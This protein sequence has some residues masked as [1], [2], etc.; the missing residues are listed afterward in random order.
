MRRFWQ[1]DFYPME[2]HTAVIEAHPH[3]TLPSVQRLA[4]C[5]TV[6][7]RAYSEALRTG[8][9]AE[10]KTS[11]GRF[12]FTPDARPFAPSKIEATASLGEGEIHEVPPPPLLLLDLPDR[13]R[14]VGLLQYLHELLL[15]LAEVR[16]WDRRPFD[17][18]RETVIAGDLRYVLQSPLK[19][20]PD[21]RH[22]A[23]VTLEVDGNGDAWL[24]LRVTTRAGEV[25]HTSEPL[26]TH[27]STKSF[28]AVRR[29]LHWLSPATVSV[30]AWPL[31]EPFGPEA[32]SLYMA[33][34]ESPVDR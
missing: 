17:K 28:N 1:V 33:G 30:D 6:V 27:L 4:K 25:V 19:A 24:W 20:S 23:G 12:I 26:M 18:A 14:R 7:T 8:P 2:A 5:G 11:W 15:Q 10:A 22:Q 13:E 16:G 29:S 21:R 3:W 9:P 34:I 31:D 32:G